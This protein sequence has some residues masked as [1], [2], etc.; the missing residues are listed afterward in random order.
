MNNLQLDRN[1]Q[2]GIILCSVAVMA[3]IFLGMYIFTGPKKA[4]ERSREDLL[5]LVDQ[6]G[7]MQ[8][9]KVSEEE[10][11]QRMS[12]LME[13]LKARPAGFNLSSYLGTLVSEKGFGANAS[14]ENARRAREVNPNL[15]LFSLSLTNVGMKDIIDVLHA[16]Y[17]SKNLIIVQSIDRMRPSE[18]GPGM[19][20][21]MTL[22]SLK[23]IPGV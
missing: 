10:R 11:V 3:L 16:I 8:A 19:D 6:H 2:I 7:T 14:F 4:Y 9:L 13:T 15:E 1:E 23:A 20:C 17:A 21:S 12:S 5:G 22:A 18:S